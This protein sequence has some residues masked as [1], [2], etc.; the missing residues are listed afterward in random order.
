MLTFRRFAPVALSAAVLAGFVPSARA[1]DQAE[2]SAQDFYNNPTS[3]SGAPCV[4]LDG[5]EVR[6]TRGRDGATQYVGTAQLGNAC[7]R[8]LDVG[9]CFLLAEPV[10]EQDEMCRSVTLAAVNGS[11]RA[12]LQSPVRIIG[13]RYEWRWVPAYVD[14]VYVGDQDN[15]ATEPS[16]AQ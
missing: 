9:F 6:E 1:Q 12:Q 7:G 11:G 15:P 8:S 10:E 5:F 16:M 3:G 4:V 13:P 2:A 14:G